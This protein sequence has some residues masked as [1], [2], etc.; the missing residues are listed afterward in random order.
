MIY[1]TTLPSRYA[2]TQQN[3]PSYQAESQSGEVAPA[4]AE[5][6]QPEMA[7]LQTGAAQPGMAQ[8][9]QQPESVQPEPMQPETV[10]AHPNLMKVHKPSGFEQMLSQE[11]DGQISLVVPS[12]E[13]VE[14]QITGQMNI[15]DIMAEW[16][17]TKRA[18]EEKRREDVRKR[19]QRHTGNMFSEFDEAT[20]SGLLEQLEKAVVEA[21]LKESDKILWIR[22]TYRN[23]SWMILSEA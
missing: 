20:K 1:P 2:M 7:Q 15:A 6:L 17:R 13:K 11:Y 14:K 9:V 22:A 8:P 23:S 19:V 21:I 18:N 16:E 5:V 4:A 12:S 3:T 10:Q